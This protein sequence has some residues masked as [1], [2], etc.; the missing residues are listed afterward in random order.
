[1]E[2]QD[3]LLKIERDLWTGGPEEYHR[4]LD[5]DCLVAFS[6]DTAGVSSREEIAGSAG[7][8]PRWHE[9]DLDARGLLRPSDDVALLTYR[10]SAR[11]G[12]EEHYEAL[13]SSCYLRRDG[14]WRMVFHQQTPLA[15]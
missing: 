1:M 2:L 6:D 8:S 12:D 3:Q 15:S 5:A 7:H 13:V 4:H 11:R 10:A 9:L 14:E